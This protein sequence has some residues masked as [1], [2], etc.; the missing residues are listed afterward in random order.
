[1]KE[2]LKDIWGFIKDFFEFL[3]WLARGGPGGYL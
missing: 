3:R 2:K 1:M